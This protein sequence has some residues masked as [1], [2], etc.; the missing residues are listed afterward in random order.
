MCFTKEI[1]NKNK[2][3]SEF[4]DV[5]VVCCFHKIRGLTQEHKHA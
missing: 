5:C 1:A 4:C 3:R 2:V